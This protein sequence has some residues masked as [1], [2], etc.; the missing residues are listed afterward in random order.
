MARRILLSVVFA[1]SQWSA[2]F[3]SLCLASNEWWFVN[4]IGIVNYAGHGFTG[5]QLKYKVG[6]LLLVI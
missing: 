3:G 5:R 4:E 1:M 6:D 2:T